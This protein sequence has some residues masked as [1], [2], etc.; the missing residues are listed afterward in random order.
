M[1]MPRLQSAL[2]TLKQI[3]ARMTA[4]AVERAKGQPVSGAEQRPCEELRKE[5]RRLMRV[6]QETPATLRRH[7][8]RIA[9]MRKEYEAARRDLAAGNLRLVISIAKRYRNRGLSLLDLIQEGNI[10]LMRAVDKFES[11]RGFRFSTYATW[12]IRQAMSRAIANQSRT[13][14]V[15]VHMIGKMGKVHDINRDLVH[16]A[17]REPALEE[18]AELSGLSI[19][20]MQW[21]LKMGRQPLSL[22]QAVGR[23][24][25]NFLGDLLY[26]HREEDPLADMNQTMLRSSIT[27]VLQTLDYREREILRLRYGLADGH[28]HTLQEIGRIFSVTRSGSA[29][30]SSR[31]S[32]SSRV[33][34][35]CAN[36]QAF[37]SDRSRR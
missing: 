10:G 6:T 14:R 27:D 35:R 8:A 13:I 16:N 17:G 18:V 21:A 36:L 22:D 9:A 29:R 30:S 1:R 24:E 19:A 3:S 34:V 7:L 20:D 12:W 23:Q 31:R 33:L 37:W 4:V 2:D 5:M 32:A 25:E 28:T 11:A 15:P 26:D